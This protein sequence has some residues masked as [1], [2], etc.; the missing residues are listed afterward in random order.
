MG[1]NQKGHKIKV[2]AFYYTR[3]EISIFESFPS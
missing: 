2:H 1:A 3:C